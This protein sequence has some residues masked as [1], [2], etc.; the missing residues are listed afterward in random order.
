MTAASTGTAPA[1]CHLN[2]LVPLWSAGPAMRSVLE[3]D[4][5]RLPFV[6][7][8][9]SAGARALLVAALAQ[10]GRVDRPILLVTATTREADDLA[11]TLGCFLPADR[12]ATFPSWETLPHERLSPRSD[13]VGRR[14]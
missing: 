4:R 1:S 5:V 6:D 3:A 10:Q 2:P 9:V 8:A 11:E 13:T 7:V 14:L 12:V